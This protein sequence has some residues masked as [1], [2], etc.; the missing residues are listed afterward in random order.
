MLQRPDARQRVAA[1]LWPEP[2]SMPSLSQKIC[3]R[4]GEMRARQAAAAAMR[5]PGQGMRLQF[6]RAAPRR[7]RI[8]QA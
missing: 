1:K 6:A 5:S 8:Q 4:A 7:A 3:G 2:S